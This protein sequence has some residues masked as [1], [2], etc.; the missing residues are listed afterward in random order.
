[1]G[2]RLRPKDHD[3]ILLL[4]QQ[5]FLAGTAADVFLSCLPPRHPNSRRTPCQIIAVFPIL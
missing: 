2:G 4:H 5:Y 1:M 3:K